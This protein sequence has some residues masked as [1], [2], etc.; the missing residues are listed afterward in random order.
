MLTSGLS[1]TPIFSTSVVIVT[2]RHH[3]NTPR[4]WITRI[5]S[6]KVII[7]TR[8][9]IIQTTFHVIARVVRTCIVITTTKRFNHASNRRITRGHGTR[10]G[11]SAL[12]GSVHAHPIG[13]RVGGT[14]VGIAALQRGKGTSVVGIA[15]IGRTSVVVVTCGGCVDAISGRARVDRTGVFVVA[16]NLHVRATT[17]GGAATA[18]RVGGTGIAV[19]AVEDR[20]VVG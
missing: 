6:T 4:F 17:G 15:R 18:N 10:I 8:N 13:T 12:Y 9:K 20:A 2:R 16:V 14:I 1:G 19:V 5:R 7:V 11:G 3:M